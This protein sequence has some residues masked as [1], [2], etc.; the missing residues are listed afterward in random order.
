VAGTASFEFQRRTQRIS[1]RMRA[2]ALEVTHNRAAPDGL[3]QAVALCAALLSGS[4][5]LGPDL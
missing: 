3:V 4:L 5:G 2:Y 1:P